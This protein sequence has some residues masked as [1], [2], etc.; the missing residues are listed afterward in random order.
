LFT[1]GYIRL[2][3]NLGSFKIVQRRYKLKKG[4]EYTKR[5]D[6]GDGYHLVT[7]V[8]YLPSQ[9]TKD[10]LN[11]YIYSKNTVKQRTQTTDVLEDL[12]GGE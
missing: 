9:R 3:C 8:I 5:K 12:L 4:K 6:S 10:I 2:P 11:S 1:N 7:K